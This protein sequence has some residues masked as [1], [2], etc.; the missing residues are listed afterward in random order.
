MPKVIAG[1]NTKPVSHSRTAVGQFD[2]PPGVPG[3]AP[4]SHRPKVFNNPKTFAGRREA[5]RQ[6]YE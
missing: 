4:L 5:S 1:R 2:G 3:S 6:R